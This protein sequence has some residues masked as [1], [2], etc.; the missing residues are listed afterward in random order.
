MILKCTHLTTEQRDSL[1]KLFSKYEELFSGKLGC[2][3]GPPVNLELK[4]EAKPFA[5]RPYTVPKSM[6][7]IAKQEIAELVRNGVLKKT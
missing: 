2:M 6:E 3:P 4:Q 1:T 5:A 7:H